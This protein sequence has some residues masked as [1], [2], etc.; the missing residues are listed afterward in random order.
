M[1]DRRQH[2]RYPSLLG[3]QISL[4]RLSSA[5]ECVIRNITPAGARIVFDH[6]V[7]M[8]REFALNIPHRRENYRTRVI[9]QRD[10]MMGVEF[11]KQERTDQP[12]ELALARRVKRLEVEKADLERRIVSTYFD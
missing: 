12:A 5:H 6:P 9:W 11:L 2:V 4:H 8:P 7:P 3:G 10:H 1:Q